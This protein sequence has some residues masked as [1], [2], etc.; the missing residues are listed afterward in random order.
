[1]S[2]AGQAQVPGLDQ[3]AVGVVTED[4]RRAVDGTLGNVEVTVVRTGDSPSDWPGPS[5]LLQEGTVVL[6]AKGLS[7]S[8]AVMAL[9]CPVVG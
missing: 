3:E 8:G 6:I 5:R 9:T 2:I 4:H 7:P 1:L